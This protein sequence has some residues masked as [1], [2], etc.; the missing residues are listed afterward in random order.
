MATQLCTML[1]NDIRVGNDNDGFIVPT[2]PAIEDTMISPRSPT[3]PV[4]SRF[5]AGSRSVSLSDYKQRFPRSFVSYSEFL[6]SYWVHLPQD[7][8][9]AL[10]ELTQFAFRPF[11]IEIQI[12][13]WCLVKSWE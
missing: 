6:A 12:L 2:T 8:T 4:Q 10:G 1:Q 3:S 9:R 11:L 7:L 5:R 13:L